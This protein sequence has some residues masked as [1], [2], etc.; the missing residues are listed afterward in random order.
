MPATPRTKRSKPAAAKG[1]K[2]KPEEKALLAWAGISDDAVCRA[3]GEYWEHWFS[4]LDTFDVRAQGHKAA[5]EHLHSLGVGDWWA[6]MV[7]VGY[8]QARGLRKKHERP[9]GFQV[10]A[11]KAIPARLDA[12]WAAWHDPVARAEFTRDDSFEVRSATVGRRMR[13]AKG[14]GKDHIEITFT[15]RYTKKGLVRTHVVAQHGKLTTAAAAEKMKRFWADSLDR[16]HKK[17]SP[18]KDAP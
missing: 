16:L 17:L 9:D 13:L 15:E 12:V 4:I 1:P 11:G 8:E 14:T 7:V 2:V 10:S 5:A 6:Q 3:T 18:L